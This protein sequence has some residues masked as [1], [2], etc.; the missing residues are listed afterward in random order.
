MK[1]I[2]LNLAVLFIAIAIQASFAQEHEMI[3][4]LQQKVMQF[5]RK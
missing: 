3:A 1:N 5:E 4:Q 2:K